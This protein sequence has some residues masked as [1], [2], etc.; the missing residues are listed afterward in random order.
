MT[1]AKYSITINTEETT[2]QDLDGWEL[3][4]FRGAHGGGA[5]P[6]VWSRIPMSTANWANRTMI[7]W[8]DGYAAYVST[9]LDIKD[10]VTIFGTSQ[11]RIDLKDIAK[12]SQQNNIVQ[13]RGT[14]EP[15]TV[16][17]RSDADHKLVG[18]LKSV[19]ASIG[20]GSFG[21]SP[22]QADPSYICALPLLG[23]TDTYVTP[24][25]KVA[26]VWMQ[27][28]RNIGAVTT[29][30]LGM[31][32]VADMEEPNRS[33]SY[34]SNKGWSDIGPDDVVVK[35]GQDEAFVDL[36]TGRTGVARVPGQH[37]TQVEHAESMRAG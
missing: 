20:S 31:T 28:P 27:R 8:E 3:V 2:R 29:K 35:R 5:K 19:P 32:L 23:Q 7:S 34:N 6:T 17:F 14:G 4:M 11:C 24:I 37:G 25:V 18:G 13:E 30:A 21:A 10:D 26:L 9:N 16:I 33:I 1:V 22:F 36:L 15:G 12:I